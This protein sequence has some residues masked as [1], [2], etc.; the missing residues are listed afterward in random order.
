LDLDEAIVRVTYKVGDVLFTREVFSSPVDQVLA[1]RITSDRPKSVSLSATLIGSKA[2]EGEC[3]G[4]EVYFYD[5]LPPDGLVVRGKTASHLGIPG[6][7]EYHSQAKAIVEGGKTVVGEMDL[8][9]KNADSVTL[10]VAAATNYVSYKDLTGK[11]EPKV[12]HWLANAAA[13]PYEELRDAHVVEHRRIFRRVHL[14]L[15]ESVAA[16]LPTDERLRKFHQEPDP[17]LVTLL[18]QYGRYLLLCSSRPGCL[19]ANLQGIWNDRMNPNW[20]S[21]Y[22]TNINLQMNYWPAEVTNLSECAQPLFKMI[23]DLVEPGEHVARVDYGVDGWVLHQNTDIWLAAAPMDGTSW[24][25]F[26][27]GGAWLCTHL[28]EH[29][30]FHQE[31]EDLKSFYP[32]MKGAAQFFVEALVEH[33]QLK[34]MVTCPSASPENVPRRPGNGPF[35][36]EVTNLYLRGTT[37]CAGPTMDMEILRSLFAACIQASEILGIDEDFRARLVK[38]REQLAPLKI[39]RYG[40]LQ[41]WLEDW[42]DPDDHHR[43]ASHLWGVYPGHSISPLKTP[44]L[45]AAAAKSLTFRGDGGTGWSMAWKVC[46]WARLLDGDHAYKLIQ[47]QLTMVESEE[48]SY[49]RGG[50]YPNLMDAH[51]PFQIDG[52]LGVTAGIAEMLLQ[53]HLGEIHLLPAIPHSWTN[54]RLEGLKAR[55]R[56]VVDMEWKN[57]KLIGASI[58]SGLDGVCRIRTHVQVTKLSC[59]SKPIEFSRP[60]QDSV[61]FRTEAGK[62][63]VISTAV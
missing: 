12:K 14:N 31:Q 34:W 52:N 1:I 41:E 47:N 20:E 44:D 26:A 59:D 48:T 45:A 42:D 11:P 5:G 21:K 36:D 51:P 37:I 18:F 25:T 33:P 50:T 15:G 19:P 43:H 2:V 9:V 10:L 8:I 62:V 35:W 53:S 30:L 17:Q 32:L 56:F 6:M 57:S 63:Y 61:E 46:L 58:H 54:G 29:Y 4:D 49:L 40:Q 27:T 28:W 7:V 23:S 22:T 38:V 55:G 39:G 3:D 60:E 24:G 16:Q 13:K